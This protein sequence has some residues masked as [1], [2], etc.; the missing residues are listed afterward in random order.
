MTSTPLSRVRPRTLQAQEAEEE[1]EEEGEGEEAP[2]AGSPVQTIGG[3]GQT[4]ELRPPVQV[5]VLRP[6]QAVGRGRKGLLCP[7]SHTSC[8][9]SHALVPRCVF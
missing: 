2:T 9:S 5:Q 8:Q 4:P 1:E 7:S 3:P 6:L